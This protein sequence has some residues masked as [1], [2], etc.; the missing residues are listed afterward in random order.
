MS[1][2]DLQL[3]SA[4]LQHD[5][6]LKSRMRV[7]EVRDGWTLLKGERASSCSSCS[8]KAGC[9]VNA[10]AEILNLAPPQLCVPAHRDAAV[11]D[12]VV[13]SISGGEF[14]QLTMLAY[15]LPTAALVVT[16][17]LATLAGLGDMATAGLSIAALA[18]S[19]LPLRRNERQSRGLSTLA[20]ESLQ[21]TGHASH[22]AA[23][24][25]GGAFPYISTENGNRQ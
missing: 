25:A 7:A 15:L 9:S 2:L 13:V 3:P 14:L 12:D 11:G 16:A 22:V 8:A 23:G 10:V 4:A 19:Y 20:V 5:R 18:L 24:Q 21:E 17:C 6:V 1:E